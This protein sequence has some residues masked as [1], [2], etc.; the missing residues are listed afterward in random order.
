MKSV[1]AR[2]L[3]GRVRDGELIGIGSGSTVELAIEEIGRRIRD[4]GLR[5]RAVPTSHRTALVAEEVG[6]E[7][8]SPVS[9][10]KL[11]W[12][13]DGADEV[14][15]ELNLI[16]GRGAAMLHEKI[17][18]R[19][20]KRLVIAITEDKLVSRL[21][22]TFSVPV[23]VIP[24]AL[25]L[26]EQGLQELGASEVVLREAAKKYGPVV[27]EDGNFVLDARF[28]S[29]RPELESKIKNLTGV[30]E[31]GLFI[32]CTDEVLVARKTGVFS[33][34]LKDGRVIEEKITE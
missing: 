30:V 27:S 17:V 28:A 11:S 13:F 19:R 2:A 32:G 8:L 20:A 14:D 22:E 12:A 1:V 21:G 26:V 34:K 5:V 16:K 4:K 29:I 25:G 3:A 23:E 18:A 7:V 9:R 24:D 15:P 6:I 33:Q 31:S 10:A